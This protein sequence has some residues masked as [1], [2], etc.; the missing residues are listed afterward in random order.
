[1]ECTSCEG[2]G[3]DV[4]RNCECIEGLY[5]DEEDADYPSCGRIC[6]EGCLRCDGK[7]KCVE[8]G[9]KIGYIFDRSG[10]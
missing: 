1:M 8:G 6:G 7:G 3:R 5:A 2:E 10:S 4:E 9:C